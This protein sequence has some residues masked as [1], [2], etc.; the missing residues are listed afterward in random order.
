[1]RQQAGDT[2]QGENE[3]QVKEQFNKGNILVSGG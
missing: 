2:G 3:H 1:M